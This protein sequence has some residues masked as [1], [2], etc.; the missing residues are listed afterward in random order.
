MKFSGNYKNIDFQIELFKEEGLGNVHKN[1][2]LEK[3]DFED[4]E[5][6]EMALYSLVIT[7]TCEEETLTHYLPGRPL[8]TDKE[9]Q[10]EELDILMEEESILD[11]L[12]EIWK[13][14]K[15]PL[16]PSWKV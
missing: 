6:G 14:A 5:R 11:N 3:E 2:V 10:I 13:K 12:E 9:D 16:G 1:Y 15:G 7:S 4:F 8:A